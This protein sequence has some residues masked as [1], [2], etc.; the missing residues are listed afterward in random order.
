VSVQ[1]Q[2]TVVDRL[3]VTAPSWAGRRPSGERPAPPVLAPCGCRCRTPQTG[4]PRLDRP[5]HGCIRLLPRR[6][7]GA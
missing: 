4:F 1:G 5:N 2:R 7:K 3:D 6:G